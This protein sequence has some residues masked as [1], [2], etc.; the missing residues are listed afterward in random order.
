MV[1]T[2]LLGFAAI[3]YLGLKGGGY[4]PL[5]H[6]QIGIA[7]WWVVLGTVL[8]G[9]LPRRRP[10]PLGLAGLAALSAFLAWTALSLSW[11]ESSEQTFAEVARVS[12]YLGFFALALLGRQSGGARRMTAAIACGIGV[13][14]LLALLSRLHPSWFGPEIHQT[15]AFLPG[16]RERLSYPIDYWNGLAALI[17]IGLPLMLHMAT[18]ARQVAVRALAAAALPAMMLTIYFT[19]SRGGIVAAAIAVVVFFA[20]TSD[21]LPKFLTALIPAAGGALL[22]AVASSH[23]SLVHGLVNDTAK[24]QGDDVLALTIVICAVI[25]VLVLVLGLASRSLERPRWTT[26]SRTTSLAALAAAV[27]VLLV[28]AIAVD[29]PG[30]ASN[31]WNEFKESTRPVGGA[32]RLG[33]VAGEARYALWSSA[34][35]EMKS[36]PL[37]GTGAGTFEF[38]W[39]RDATVPETVIDTHSLYL[40]VLGELGIVGFLLIVGFLALVL[41]VGALVSLRSPARRR[42]ALAAAL[43]GCAAFCITA[44]VDWVWQ[45]PVVT[46]A[47][48]LLAAMLLSAGD[49]KAAEG[50]AA[51]AWL[52]RG[53]VVLAS[54]ILIIAI[55]VPLASTSM[56]RKSQD[57]AREGDVEG[58]LADARTAQ[59]VEPFAATPRL[60]EALLHEGEGDLVAAADAARG[61]TERE[62]TNWRT[63]LVLSRIEAK[64]GRAAASVAAYR[65]ARSLN[66]LSPV[67]RR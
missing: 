57:K 50:R 20:F 46:V 14:A 25:G 26:P 9:A 16:S 30:R 17:A 37:E 52:P 33:S 23:H 12:V 44:S 41:V 62:S 21:R 67:F 11:T 65:K 61:A 53:V 6:D 22:I 59:D 13:V 60:Q 28:A 39:S 48:L 49:A 35:R 42:P 7:V 1:L 55:A 5:V 56:L 51:L 64:R 43:A 36:A 19:L 8:V 32:N 15:A 40:Q 10:G 47:M 66:P 29:A 54:L 31:G 34:V 24:Q 63:W 58:A 38:W 4:D 18:D 2:W 45:V 27:V 3:V